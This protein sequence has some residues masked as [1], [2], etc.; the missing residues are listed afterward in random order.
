MKG[1]GML[2]A[3]LAMGALTTYAHLGDVAAIYSGYGL[4][5]SMQVEHSASEAAAKSWEAGMTQ[6][7]INAIKQ[8]VTGLSKT[9]AGQSIF[10][11]SEKAAF[12][13]EYAAMGGDVTPGKFTESMMN[14]FANYSQAIGGELS[15]SAQDLISQ[16][17][18]WYKGDDVF[19][20]SNLKKTSD[21][22]AVLVAQTKLQAEDLNDIS[23]YGAPVANTYGM[24]P[25]EYYAAAGGLAQMGRSPEQAS[26]DIRRMLLRGTPNVSN[27]EKM[28]AYNLGL[29][30]E[31]GQ[32]VDET[33]SVV[34]QSAVN[35]A[36]QQLGMSWEDLN[37]KN[38]G[39][40]PKLME[41]IAQKMDQ[42]GMSEVD[43]Q[44]WMK[45]VYGIQGVT[46]ASMLG[47][48][49]DYITELQKKLEGASEGEGATKSM[50]DIQT[51]NLWGSGKKLL[52]NIQTSASALG[53]R[54]NPSVKGFVDYLNNSAVPSMNKFGDAIL[55]GRY[56]EA[57]EMIKGFQ[58]KV[59]DSVEGVSEKFKDSL[60]GDK[61]KGALDWVS[62]I[63]KSVDGGQ[64]QK[65]LGNL[66]EGVESALRSAMEWIE[67][68]DWSSVEDG[69]GNALESAGGWLEEKIDNIDW[70]DVGTKVGNAF[71]FA[72]GIVE[73]TLRAVPWESVFKALG[74]EIYG[75]ASGIDWAGALTSLFNLLKSIGTSIYNGLA[76][77]QI[78]IFFSQIVYDFESNMRASLATIL[79][80][81]YSIPASLKAKATDTAKSIVSSFNGSGGSNKVYI[82]KTEEGTYKAGDR[83]TKQYIE[84]SEGST[85]LESVGKVRNQVKSR[86]ETVSFVDSPHA[87]VQQHGGAY[88]AY[89]QDTGTQI[90]NTYRSQKS[91]SEEAVKSLGYSIVDLK[92]A[93]V[94]STR[95][96]EAAPASAGSTANLP[97]SS[98][99]GPTTTEPTTSV[100][101]GLKDYITG[102]DINK[103]EP[104][105]KSR[106]DKN[107]V[108]GEE[109]FKNTIQDIDKDK[110]EA[111]IAALSKISNVSDVKKASVLT[112]MYTGIST[113]Y[114]APSN[115]ASGSE[116]LS[117]KSVSDWKNSLTD[118]FNKYVSEPVNKY[119]VE[120]VDKYVVEP[121]NNNVIKPAEELIQDASKFDLG[122]WARKTFLPSSGDGS[123]DTSGE[124]PSGTDTDKSSKDE[125]I[126]SELLGF[127]KSDSSS[128]EETN[129][130]LSKLPN[131]FSKLIDVEKEQSVDF[132]AL[133]D[134]L[135]EYSKTH[136]G[137]P[138]LTE[139]QLEEK[140]KNFSNEDIASYLLNLLSFTKEVVRPELKKIEENT[141][142][143]AEE[144]EKP[145]TDI[146]GFDTEGYWKS[147]MGSTP[148]ESISDDNSLSNL[149]SSAQSLASAASAYSGAV[150]IG[151]DQNNREVAVIGKVRQ[152]SWEE[153]G[154]S[155]ADMNNLSQSAK[156][157]L[158]VGNS[159]ITVSPKVNESELS[160]IKSDIEADPIDVKLT[161][162]SEDLDAKIEETKVPT[163]S[164]HT[165]KVDDSYVKAAIA[166]NKVP[167]SSVHTIYINQVN[168]GNRSS[169][170]PSLPTSVKGKDYSGYYFYPSFAEGGYTGNY[171]G[172]AYLHPHERIT[173]DG[174]VVGSDSASSKSIQV[175][176]SLD[177]RGSTITGDSAE[178][179]ASK[180]AS[181]VKEKMEQEMNR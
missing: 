164:F 78:G 73:K 18:M 16:N 161:P 154:N 6:D 158:S 59:L 108:Y 33:G 96:V 121:I 9:G 128:K 85:Y 23:K 41:N 179:F 144:E 56:D 103:G 1:M 100:P 47:Q 91:E 181:M 28:E 29:T 8:N 81:I 75:V 82:Y 139:S 14:L 104:V 12:L 171:E 163:E 165:I 147:V 2:T 44:A 10:G 4:Y 157:S 36:L 176:L 80:D 35:K 95:A 79:A 69:L 76:S 166:N 32:I 115:N 89:D 25:E 114:T 66:S 155:W 87:Y 51:D 84:G 137:V 143:I 146:K 151:L 170:T 71:E 141:E 57:G 37:V 122:E 125:S 50:S 3:P 145:K 30:N 52:A 156:N 112:E 67:S 77:S 149:S 134:A 74:D 99:T 42:A 142:E 58:G 180:I 101:S 177:L 39:G 129:D 45:T 19:K 109:S 160:Q 105:W 83:E 34:E 21:M 169:S 131:E 110:F 150:R 24:T 94:D 20:E 127:F 68:I 72:A 86:G 98:T 172:L 5:K 93:V 107:I 173:P 64:I 174:K 11:P 159:I 178:I 40:L 97:S 90:P 132:G 106:K 123:G 136:S 62:D 54:L 27:Q 148:P 117:I 13:A 130:L 138:L 48:G 22:N 53:D 135:S 153:E 7:E 26:T 140:L 162:N 120:P 133:S 119:V 102:R 15:T 111:G 17:M 61:V 31:K 38:A 124:I 88:W 126:A 167:T 152:R 55:N 60:S 116:K 49:K 63:F 175:S 46:P 65:I 92:D 43:Q 118:S 113:K 168:S 70:T